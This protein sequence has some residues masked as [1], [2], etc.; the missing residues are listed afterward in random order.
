LYIGN[1][2]SNRGKYP[3][4]QDELTPLFAVK[5]EIVSVSSK[6]GHFAKAWDMLRSFIREAPRSDVIL[7]DT[8]STLNFYYALAIALLCQ[9]YN[10]PYINFLHGGGL[11]D[12]LSNNPFLSRLI[13]KHS[14]ALV[15]PSSYMQAH[16][17]RK[18]YDTVRIPNILH[19]ENYFFRKRSYQKARL[20]WLRSFRKHYNPELA[21]RVLKRLLDRGIDADLIMVGP[22]S[23]DGS[24][25]AVESYIRQN[26]LSEKVQLP[27]LLSK[28]EWIDLTTTRNILI[29]TTTID[30]TP[31]SVIECMALGLAIISTN[32]GGIP[33]LLD[34]DADAMLVPSGDDLLMTEAVVSLI[35]QP[36]KASEMANNARKKVERFDWNVVQAE[37]D[38]LFEHVRKT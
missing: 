30:T 11:P 37:W 38:N 31:V 8:F 3:S 33:Y 18:G 35:K 10:K 5:Y 13:F 25:E 22:D 9:L 17:E 19:L 16:F 26:Q 24:K 4:V 20:F 7:I 29:N 6:S 14:S 27:G 15:A 21:V 28:N 32:V 23:G 1:R 2:T 36:D 12:R 34:H